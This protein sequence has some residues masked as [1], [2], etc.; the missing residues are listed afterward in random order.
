MAGIQKALIAGVAVGSG[1]SGPHNTKFV[2]DDF[3]NGCETVGGAASI[4]DNVMTDR[5][6]IVL[7]DTIDKGGNVGAFA[8]GSDQD[9]LGTGFDVAR[10]AGIVAEN[11]G[12]FND[13]VDLHRFPGEVVRVAV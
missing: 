7:V 1:H 11:A 9:F 8:G 10:S 4:A 3:E 12:C 13:K 2:E 6:I 5:V